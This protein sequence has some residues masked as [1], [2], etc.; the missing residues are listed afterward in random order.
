MIQSY[1]VSK[2][3]N[4]VSVMGGPT[5]EHPTLGPVIPTIKTFAYYSDTSNCAADAIEQAEALAAE[6]NRTRAVS[7]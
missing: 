2:D 7:A 3:D 6:L 4:S 5:V 1:Y